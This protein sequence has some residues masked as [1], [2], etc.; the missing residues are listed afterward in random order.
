M[1]IKGIEITPFVIR[2][3]IAEWLFHR[4]ID[5][6]PPDKELVFLDSMCYTLKQKYKSKKLNYTQQSLS[7]SETKVSS[8]KCSVCGGDTYL[9]RECRRC[10]NGET[11][12]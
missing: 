8:P 5:I 10:E 3:L 6:L 4:V 7:G 1:V 2:S 9:S 12:E 11:V